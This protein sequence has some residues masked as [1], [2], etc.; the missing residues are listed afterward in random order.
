MRLE[1]IDIDNIKF[2]SRVREEYGDIDSLVLSMK[3][4]GIIQP[5]AV[6]HQPKEEKKYLL[7]AGGRRY[8]AARKADIKDIPVRIYDRDLGKLEI[9]TIE[10]AENLY[11]KDLEWQE[12]VKL[13][14]DIHDLQIEIHGEKTSTSPNAEGW[15]KRDTSTMLNESPASTVQD[16]QL[17]DML[18]QIPE[19]QKCKNK[20]EAQKIIKKAKDTF[21]YE[22]LATQITTKQN[23]TPDDKLRKDIIDRYIIK[24][25]FEG[26]K[27][28]PDSS[29]DLVEIDPP[30]GID[31]KGIKKSKDATNTVVSEYNEV[32]SKEYEKFM[33]DTLKASYKKMKHGGCIILWFGPEPWFQNMYDW[34]VD[35]GFN[36][37]RIPGIWAKGTGQTMQPKRYLANA[38]EMFF[39]GFKGDP[40][41]Q[42]QGRSNVFDFRPVPAGKKIH[43]TERP[44]EMIEEVLR[45]FIPLNSTVMVPFLGS[46]N[47]LLACANLGLESFGYDLAREYKDKFTVKVQSSKPP[48]YKS[49]VQNVNTLP[50]IEGAGL[51]SVF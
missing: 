22:E 40:A 31:L 21:M 18:Y 30:Y 5:L 23:K 25:F 29:V 8:T 20:H 41:I 50:D 14:K 51:N 32:D 37:R 26:I 36:T 48:L 45:T 3:K 43:P 49:Y 4:D 47:T 11:R 1:T 10:L 42:K 28:V 38:Y 33:T 17:A 46:G 13:K 6:K 44:I 9:K 12:E 2:G 27:K 16:I 24:D 15:S 7:L 35:A 39:Y 34:M 19:L